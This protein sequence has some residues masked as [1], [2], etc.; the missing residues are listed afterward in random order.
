M[1]VAEFHSH[2]D[3]CVV[4]GWIRFVFLSRDHVSLLVIMI[5]G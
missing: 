2:N 5:K 4:G 1:N 3:F